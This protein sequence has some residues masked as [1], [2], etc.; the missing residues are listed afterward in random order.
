MLYTHTRARIKRRNDISKILARFYFSCTRGMCIYIIISI[1]MPYGG[2]I[3]I[4]GAITFTRDLKG[5]KKP[6]ETKTKPINRY[7]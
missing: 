5:K 3:K 6:R 2:I 4:I 7:L 1:F